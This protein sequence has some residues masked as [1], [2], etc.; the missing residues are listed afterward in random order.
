MYIGNPLWRVFTGSVSTGHYNW[1]TPGGLNGFA[2]V[3][4]ASLCDTPLVQGQLLRVD[5]STHQI[6][7]TLNVVPDGQL[8]GTIWTKPVVD[9]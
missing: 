1:S 9:A 7:N 8:G 2:Y 6:A 5:M 4:I 3:G